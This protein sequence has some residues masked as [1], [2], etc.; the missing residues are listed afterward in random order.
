MTARDV[1]LL[2][3]TA[4]YL[5]SLLLIYDAYYRPVSTGNVGLPAVSEPS[6]DL[7]LP[8]PGASAMTPGIAIGIGLDAALGTILRD[9]AATGIVMGIAVGAACGYF[10]PR[11]Q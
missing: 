6:W 4:F 11:K 3:F 2:F 1:L 9:N 7:L 10:F 5:A 8:Y